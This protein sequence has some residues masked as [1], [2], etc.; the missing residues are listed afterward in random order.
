MPLVPEPGDE[1]IEAMIGKIAQNL[2][3]GGHAVI[4]RVGRVVELTGAEPAMALGQIV[5]DLVAAAAAQIAGEQDH[6]AAI[7]PDQLAAL[8]G[9]GIPHDGDEF[10]T[11]RG[12]HHGKGDADIAR[13]AF[14]NRIARLEFAAPLGVE[15]DRQRKPVLDGTA[16][17]EGFHLDVNG[18][19]FRRYVVETDNRGSADGVEDGIIKSHLEVPFD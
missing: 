9:I 10:V 18:Y 7:G 8:D 17:V 14:D 6:L 13:S 15:H 5:S 12:R 4:G 1:I 19:V 3:R 16:G 11:A 2:G